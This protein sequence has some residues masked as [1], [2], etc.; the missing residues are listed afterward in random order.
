MV[1]VSVSS[2][3]VEQAL[4]AL[5]RKLQREVVFRALKIQRYFEKPSVKRKRK[6][7]EA[8]DRFHQT[9][10]RLNSMDDI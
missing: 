9:R 7:A 1:Q 4:K 10:R 2:G 3:N 6:A 5:K 8:L